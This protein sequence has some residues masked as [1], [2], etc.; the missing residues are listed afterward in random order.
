[1]PI[2]DLRP[3]KVD[4]RLP[5]W[6]AGLALLIAAVPLL[7]WTGELALA[8]FPVSVGVTAARTS[9]VIQIE[10]QNHGMTA[11]QPLAGLRGDWL[12]AV[13]EAGG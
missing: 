12:I 10:G 6:A 7:I 8:L 1:M 3:A 13:R 2:V 5:P 11:A 4:V 9:V